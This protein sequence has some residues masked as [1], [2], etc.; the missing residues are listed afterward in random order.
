MTIININYYIDKKIFSIFILFTLFYISYPNNCIG[1]ENIKKNI[2]AYDLSTNNNLSFAKNNHSLYEITNDNKK[3]AAI[4]SEII[5]A[6][7]YSLSEQEEDNTSNNFKN[8]LI[9]SIY[10]QLLFD[11]SKKQWKKSYDILKVNKNLFFEWNDDEKKLI[12]KQLL[13]FFSY[14]DEGDRLKNEQADDEALASYRT[15]MI[16]AR[17]LPNHVKV[18]YIA[19]SK[20]EEIS[21][22]EKYEIYDSIEV[23]TN[24][25]DRS[26]EK[27]INSSD[28]NKLAI[29]QKYT[30]DF[31]MDFVYIKSGSFLMGTKSTKI[32]STD[33]TQHKVTFTEG[34]YIAATEITYKQWC[35]VMDFHINK[36]KNNLPVT[37]VT[38]NEIDNYIAKLNKKDI[39][40]NYRLPSEAEW[41]YACRAGT[42]SIYYNGD[43]SNILFNNDDMSYCLTNDL[44]NIYSKES[45]ENSCPKMVENK[46]KVIAVKSYKSN[47][48]GLFDMYGNVR[49]LCLDYYANYPDYSVINPVQR[50]T[51]YQ[52][53]RVVRGGSFKTTYHKCRSSARD[54]IDVGGYKKKSKKLFEFPRR[55]DDVGFRLVLIKKL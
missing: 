53:Y 35:N 28:E 51:Q 15:A 2:K 20:I 46:N 33:E 19:N 1:R 14:I 11:L 39:K 47:N 12:I 36:E 29:R 7:D 31:D 24:R 38:I 22:T 17:N 16:V 55:W 4:K 52:E 32:I 45:Y 48:W 5:I 50:D 25:V 37:N 9:S 40:N 8:N 34:F 26:I 49:E 10:N 21:D 42:S 41:E 30:N 54:Y 18:R 23:M 43:N 6:M 27:S 44:A 3:N 13:S